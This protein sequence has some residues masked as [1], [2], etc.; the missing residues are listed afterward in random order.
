MFD[1]G[2]RI[3]ELRK[4]NNVTAVKLSAKLGISQG[5]LSRIENNVN[6]AQFD[7]IM[8]I[9]DFFSITLSEF[10]NDDNSEH[11]VLTSELKE[12]LNS[13]KDL[14]PSQLEAIQSIIKAIKEGR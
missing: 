8:R 1:L 13:A 11:I 7:T 12:L 6:T 4:L 10:F 9:C 2:A 3:R 14:T 5:Q